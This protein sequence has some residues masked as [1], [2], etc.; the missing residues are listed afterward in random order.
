MPSR[1]RGQLGKVF[2]DGE[3]IVRQGEVGDRM[4]VVQAGKVEVVLESGDVV[5]A[6]RA[7]TVSSS[8]AGSFWV[9]GGMKPRRTSG[10]SLPKACM[11]AWPT[12]MRRVFC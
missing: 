12:G 4:F 6:S 9:A 5:Q 3:V 7:G 11:A 2:K 1:R 8:P 10:G